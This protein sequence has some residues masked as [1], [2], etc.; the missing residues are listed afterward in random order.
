M[1]AY[2]AL[3][4]IRCP[5]KYSEMCECSNTDNSPPD[6]PRC[7][8]THLSSLSIQELD[9]DTICYHHRVQSLLPLPILML[10]LAIGSRNGSLLADDRPTCVKMTTSVKNA[11]RPKMRT[12]AKRF[13]VDEV[14]TCRD[15]L[16]LDLSEMKWGGRKENEVN[17]QCMI[18]L[19]FTK[20][21]H[22]FVTYQ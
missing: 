21:I 7:E 6:V 12:I 10:G 18:I 20:I 15:L 14:S 5:L 16:V 8:R 2:T 22:W 17:N 9:K 1:L 3:T 11:M 4:C 13:I 19:T